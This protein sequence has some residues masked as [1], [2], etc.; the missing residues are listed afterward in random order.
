VTVVWE[1]QP[2]STTFDNIGLAPRP[3]GLTT[4][5][6]L[7]LETMRRTI[8]D[9]SNHEIEW[10]YRQFLAGACRRSA[11]A[12]QVSRVLLLGE[13]TNISEHKST[14]AIQNGTMT[15]SCKA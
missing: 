6:R 4:L 14:I 2:S 9:D 8:M 1:A 12:G 11:N 10:L 5:K 13:L 15:I 3:A 7:M